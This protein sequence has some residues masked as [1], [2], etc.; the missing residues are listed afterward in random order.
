VPPNPEDQVALTLGRALLAA[1][2]V[3][4]EQSPPQG[5]QR[6]A[7]VNDIDVHGIPAEFAGRA[8]LTRREFRAVVRRSETWC[9]EQERAGKIRFRTIDGCKFVGIEEVRRVVA[10]DEGSAAV[11]AIAG[12]RLGLAGSPRVSS[13]EGGGRGRASRAGGKTAAQAAKP[14]AASS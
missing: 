2:A 4:S 9:R 12:R 7:P 10:G 1:L 11:A 13:S 14:A 3:A 8:L 6:A 5:D